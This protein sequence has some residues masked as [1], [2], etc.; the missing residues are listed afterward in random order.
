MTGK[1]NTL[2]EMAK[3]SNNKLQSQKARSFQII[4]ARQHTVAL[5]EEWVSNTISKHIVSTALG[6]RKHCLKTAQIPSLPRNNMDISQQKHK[7]K[8]SVSVSKV[9]TSPS[10]YVVGRIVGHECNGQNR[11]YVVRWNE[12]GPEDDML[13][14]AGNFPQHFISQYIKW[15]DQRQASNQMSTRKE[16]VPTPTTNTIERHF[17]SSDFAS[18]TTWNRRDTNKDISKLKKPQDTGKTLL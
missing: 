2:N 15:I 13:K 14:A 3:A 17:Q 4:K 1:A 11:R 9:P 10:E 12:A 7:K 5:E 8:R 18:S 16:W 6:L